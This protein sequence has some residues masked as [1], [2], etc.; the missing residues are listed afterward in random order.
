MTSRAWMLL[1][2][3][4]AITGC[5]FSETR[6]TGVYVLLDPSGVAAEQS[7]GM[8]QQLLLVLQSGDSL[9]MAT[10]DSDHFGPNNRIAAITFASRPILANQQKRVF[11]QTVRPYFEAAQIHRQSDVSGGFLHA[12]DYLDKTRA[13]RKYILLIADLRKT[14]AGGNN[15][16][17]SLP[18]K[19]VQVVVPDPVAF[20]G[21]GDD[22]KADH[23]QA[24]RWREIIEGNRGTWHSIRG[25]EA[26]RRLFPD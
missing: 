24:Q 6:T 26:L 16:L 11:L 15:A 18:L 21:G 8:V 20:A 14:P 1:A 4:I 25:R 3:T 2:A 7:I 19:G 5:W 23:R 17:A 9:A 22:T 12:I 13:T 10:I